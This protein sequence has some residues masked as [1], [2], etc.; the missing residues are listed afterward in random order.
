MQRQTT[1]LGAQRPFPATPISPVCTIGLTAA[2]APDLPAY[3][4]WRPSE[5]LSDLSDRPAHYNATGNL[6]PFLK[7]QGYQG[8]PARHRHDP[9]MEY[10]NPL[11]AGLVL[12]IQRPRYRRSTLPVL[13][14]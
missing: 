13:P 10:Y 4:R 6:F 3:C 11:N 14:A 1:R 7:P 2:V 9:A 8:P 5:A 12:P